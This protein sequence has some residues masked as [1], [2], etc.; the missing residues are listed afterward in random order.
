MTTCNAVSCSDFREYL[1][2]SLVDVSDDDTSELM[3]A[4]VQ[5]HSEVHTI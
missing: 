1:I 5:L 2:D 3:N 4:I